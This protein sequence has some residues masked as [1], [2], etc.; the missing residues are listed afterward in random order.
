MMKKIWITPRLALKFKIESTSFFFLFLFFKRH[1]LKP[2]MLNR[3]LVI[4][5]LQDARKA[6]AD[7]TLSQVKHTSTISFLELNNIF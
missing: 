6:C 7:A 1:R 2:P 3:L 5:V 4:V